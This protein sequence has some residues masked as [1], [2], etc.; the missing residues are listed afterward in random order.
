M[1]I[2]K[3]CLR[4]LRH[5]TPKKPYASNAWFKRG[6][7]FLL[8]L[9]VLREAKKPLT[10]TEIIM[11]MFAKRGVASPTASARRIVRNSIHATLPKYEGKIL[12]IHGDKIPRC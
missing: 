5:N 12:K 1:K 2:L 7:G 3:S 11:G 9:D 10:Q 8:A 4:H 6:E